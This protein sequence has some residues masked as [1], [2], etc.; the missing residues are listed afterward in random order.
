MV[1]KQD[2]TPIGRRGTV[3]KHRGKGATEQ[4]TPPGM[5]ESLTGPASLGRALNA[6]PKAPVTPPSAPAFP[7]TPAVPA[8]AP[9]AGPAAGPPTPNG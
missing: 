5:R 1:F 3:T 8:G 4:R 2:L 9:T 7:I 6:Y